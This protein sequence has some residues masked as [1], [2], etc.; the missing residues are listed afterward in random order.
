MPPV[1]S[2]PSPY[3]A[4]TTKS[5]SPVTPLTTDA[6]QA[7]E[8]SDTAKEP[9]SG[10][11]RSEKTGKREKRKRCR[12]TPEQLIQ[13]EDI[14]NKDRNPTGIR[15]K[16]ISDELGMQE[17]QTQIWFQNRRAK[18][19]LLDGKAGLESPIGAPA[20]MNSLTPVNLTV[21][22]NEPEAFDLIPCNELSIGTWRRIASTMGQY[23]LVAYT[24]EAKRCIT[25]F[26]Q[27]SGRGFKMELSYDSIVDIGFSNGN[28]G[29]GEAVFIVDRPP[30]FYLEQ[31]YQPDFAQPMPKFW[32]RCTD[33]TEDLQASQVLCHTL[34]GPA[35]MLANIVRNLNTR[36]LA[37]NAESVSVRSSGLYRPHL[38]V[39]S[40]ALHRGQYIMPP[41]ISP[42]YQLEQ[43]SQV[44]AQPQPLHASISS[45]TGIKLPSAPLFGVSG[46]A[47]NSELDQDNRFAAVPISRGA[48]LSS[49]PSHPP[50]PK[51]SSNE[52]NF[53]NAS[54]FNGSPVDFAMSQSGALYDPTLDIDP[55]L[56]Q[57]SSPNDH[58]MA[59]YSLF[60]DNAILAG[61]AG[62]HHAQ[63]EF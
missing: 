14:F 18:A 7:D 23:D 37:T 62:G 13:L 9:S 16:E 15:R 3:S 17:R 34:S 47:D 27:S 54:L 5:L 4:D 36:I 50:P 49:L 59:F 58:G 21:L 46:Y 30:M 22:M 24:C 61:A 28:T 60:D 10:P 8:D 63:Y 26:I 2:T 35:A 45:A 33:W 55:S 48:R 43:A 6:E 12:V 29:D 57:S 56:L 44:L 19:K 31:A 51:D 39:E 32:K 20:I 53:F 52:Q 25:W 41:S 40:N 11:Q 1:S 42:P 38:S